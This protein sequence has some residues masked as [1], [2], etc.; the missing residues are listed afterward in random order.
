MFLSE[1]K[2]DEVYDFSALDA[3]GNT[4]LHYAAAGGAGYRHLKALIDVG[5]DPYAANTSG[6][7]FIYCLRPIQPFTLEPNSD[8]LRSDDLISLLKLLQPERVF[9][10][11]DN[12]GQTI[13]HALCSKISEPELR[14]RILQWVTFYILICMPRHFITN[15]TL[16]MFQDA[17]YPPT[18]RDRFGR[19]ARDIAP[20]TYDCHGQVIDAAPVKLDGS[21]SQN[22]EGIQEGMTCE[23]LI[24]ADWRLQ[25]VKQIKAQNILHEA[26]LNPGYR[27]PESDDNVLHALSRLKSSNDTLLNLAHFDSPDA[28]MKP[29]N[30]EG[31]QVL[32]NLEHFVPRGVD[33][34]LQ[35][36]EGDYPLKSFIC[37]R[38]W[39]DNETGATM[40]KYLDA[41]LWKSLK[42]RVKNNINVN[43]KDREGSTALHCAAVRGRPDS[44]R[45]LIEAGAN[46]NA[47]SGM[48]I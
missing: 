33:L 21:V 34:N 10:W 12:D 43:L 14:S 41:M 7:L 44:V 31:N 19:T 5:V 30:R 17:G 22:S 28:T 47:R 16:R 37:D 18:L 39:E 26:R 29:Q 45:S 36:R 23:D 9:D 1:L 35:N 40:S 11:R 38:P 25:R 20:L 42:Q 46:V 8:C 6:E 32:L 2:L 15:S 27:D 24:T 48:L 13:L 3:A 4:A